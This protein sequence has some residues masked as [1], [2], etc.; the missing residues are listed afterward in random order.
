L[1]EGPVC[2]SVSASKISVPRSSGDRF[3]DWVVGLQFEPNNSTTQPL[4]TPNFRYNE[5]R[6]HQALGY[7]NRCLLA[8]GGNDVRCGHDNAAA[9]PTCPQRQQQ[10][11]TALAT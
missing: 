11:T 9:L 10:Q 5:Q 7:R 8:R 6:L 3:D 2:G 1:A 4:Q